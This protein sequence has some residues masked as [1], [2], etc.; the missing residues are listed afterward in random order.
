MHKKPLSVVEK[1]SVWSGDNQVGQKRLIFMRGTPTNGAKV[2]SYPRNIR[3]KLLLAP[4]A[5]EASMGAF[6]FRERVNG[7]CNGACGYCYAKGVQHTEVPNQGAS[8]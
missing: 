1:L 3:K 8:W 4:K 6:Y 2:A 5:S 7:C